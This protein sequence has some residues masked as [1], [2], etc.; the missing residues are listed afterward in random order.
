[1][2]HA[3]VHLKAILR[4]GLGRVTHTCEMN[5]TKLS[6]FLVIHILKIIMGGEKR[7]VRATGTKQLVCTC[8]LCHFAYSFDF[9]VYVLQMKIALSCGMTSCSLERNYLLK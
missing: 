2:I 4:V 6:Q 3:D 8:V 7:S 5:M 9:Q 1:M